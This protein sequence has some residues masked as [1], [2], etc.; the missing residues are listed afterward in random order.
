M[1][2][3]S[4]N[5]SIETFSDKRVR[6]GHDV[7]NIFSQ[8]LEAVGR[9]GYQSAEATATEEPL[10]EQIAQ[11]VS[12]WFDLELSGRYSSV[13]NRHQLE[14]SFGEL[15]VRAHSE[16]GYIDPKTFLNNLTSDE[17]GVVQEVNFLAKPIQ[18]DSLTEEGALNLLIPPPAQV[19]LNRDGLTQTGI[20]YGIRFPDSSTPA[21]VVR[22]WDAATQGMTFE[23]KGLRELQ[24]VLPV[25]LANIVTDENGAYVRHYDPGD[26]EWVNPMAVAG[27]S[28]SKVSQ[29]QLDSLNYFRSQMNPL[30]YDEGIQFWSS[31][32]ERLSA[33]E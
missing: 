6:L 13:E 9:E 32:Q 17:L 15:V 2:I 14:Q 19:D 16:G 21:N 5:A 18:V 4:A 12:N 20:G 25:L 27:Y 22:A 30:R 28:Y 1:K 11:S 7:Q 23:E 31:F 8:V 29:D 24:M 26:P 33:N 10:T 3:E